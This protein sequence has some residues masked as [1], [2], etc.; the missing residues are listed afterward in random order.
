MPKLALAGVTLLPEDGHATLQFAAV[1]GYQA[2]ELYGDF[3]QAH[4]SDLNGGTREKLRRTAEE[5]GISLSVHA[6]WIDLNV[7]SIN[8]GIQAE[9]VRQHKGTLDMAADLGAGVVV[10]H[11]G[12]VSG[13]VKIGREICFNHSIESIK[14][15]AEHA[16]RR[17]LLLCLEN[18]LFEPWAVDKTYRDLLT[19]QERVGCPQLRFTFDFGHARLEKN[20]DEGL[21]ALGQDIRHIHL[22]D[23]FGKADDH[24]VIGQG[25]M[26]YSPYLDFLRSFQGL[27]VL[28]VRGLVENG[29]GRALESREYFR[30]LLAGNT[31]P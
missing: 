9:S 28:E 8:R 6:P 18:V 1:N 25:S 30:N 11:A 3:P 31:S 19:I 17:D 12:M 24:L 26:D 29:R 10:M 13:G 16:A 22:S 5:A 20:I 15:I 2:L 14:E 4:F 7:A 21:K 27:I 23:N